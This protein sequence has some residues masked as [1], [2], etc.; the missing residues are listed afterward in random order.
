VLRRRATHDRRFDT[1]AD[2]RRSVR[3]GRSYFQTVRER[4]RSRLAGR[5]PK[6]TASP[7]S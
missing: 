7:G 1:T 6:Q 5:K 4:V 3:N 2:P